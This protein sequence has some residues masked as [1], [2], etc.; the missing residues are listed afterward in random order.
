MKEYSSKCH[1]NAQAIDD[2]CNIYDRTKCL[3][4]DK[5]IRKK[6]ELL[7]VKEKSE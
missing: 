2:F 6:Y 5:K 4:K 1:D 7:M 3:R